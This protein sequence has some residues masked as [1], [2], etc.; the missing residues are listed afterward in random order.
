VF[1]PVLGRLEEWT[2]KVLVREE[3]NPRV[4]LRDLSSELLSVIDADNIKEM[5]RGVLSK[6]FGAE[7]VEVIFAEEVLSMKN[8]DIYASKVMD[9]LLQIGE[10]LGRLDFIEAMG[11]LNLKGRIFPRPGRKIIN[12]AVATLPGVV[13]RFAGFDL[14]V[15][16]VHRDECAAVLLLGPRREHRHYSSEEQAL[17][18]MLASQVAASLSRIELLKEVVDKKVMEEELNLARS[19]QL[20]LLPSSPPRL[21]NYEVSALS[22]S[23]KQVGGDY[24]DFIHN[25]AFLAIA[26]ADVSGKGVP[27]SLLMASLQASLRSTMDR[28]NDPVGVVIRLNDVMFETTAP[29]KFATLFYGC[30]D[31]KKHELNYTNAGHFFPVVV[32]DDLKLDVLDYS[33]LI[34]GVKPGFQY[35]SRKLKLRPGDILVVTTDGVI[36]AEGAS[37]DLYG[38]ERLRELLS[39]MK[40][41]SADEVK[42][43]IVDSVNSFSY[44]RGTRDDMTILVLKRK[45]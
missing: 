30:L 29:E 35:E 19:I 14:V 25:D 1:Q 43:G 33:G 38:E 31:M 18:S 41:R 26:V 34:L 16:V 5:V 32:R 11:F 28:M 6:V 20:N 7:D 12:E 42:K 45:E 4:R 8:D 39:S 24:Y 37:G 44:P 23:S 36:E 2:E 13:R 17:L 9:V 22:L 40:G 21:E 3:R 10:P 27:A 15:P